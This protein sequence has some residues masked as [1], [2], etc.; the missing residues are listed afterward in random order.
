VH[1]WGRRRTALAAL[2][3]LGVVAL[4]VGLTSLA[5]AG[6]RPPPAADKTWTITFRTVGAGC[7]SIPDPPSLT[8]ATG[9]HITLVN[10]TG[11][12]VLAD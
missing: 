2:F 7:S 10:E 12:A 4:A 9:N 6:A 1:L 5:S 11:V 3:S 8:V